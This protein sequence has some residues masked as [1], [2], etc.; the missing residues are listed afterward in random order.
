M[1]ASASESGGGGTAGEEEI[2]LGVG[3]ATACSLL[4]IGEMCFSPSSRADAQKQGVPLD[5]DDNLRIDG[6]TLPHSRVT[7]AQV[8]EIRCSF[9]RRLALE[10]ASRH[11][12][13]RSG[14][15]LPCLTP[16]GL[17]QPVG[18]TRRWACSGRCN[19][20]VPR[21]HLVAVGRAASVP[22]RYLRSTLWWLASL[23]QWLG[24][25]TGLRS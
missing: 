11:P 4:T 25:T 24:G 1:H 2:A 23:R 13:V 9:K 18:V 10:G 12:A 19:Q 16:G 21:P 8:R 6:V 5:I 22:S 20:E 15:G 3:M 14:R 7:Y 17:R